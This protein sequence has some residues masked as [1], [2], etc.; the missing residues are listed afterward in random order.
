MVVQMCTTQ[1]CLQEWNEGSK[2]PSLAQH[3]EGLEVSLSL[4]HPNMHN[5]SK[6]ISQLLS[7]LEVNEIITIDS[8]ITNR[9]LDYYMENINKNPLHTL[10]IELHWHKERIWKSIKLWKLKKSPKRLLRQYLKMLHTNLFY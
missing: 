10:K 8:H 9:I 5:Q 3:I 1:I 2:K 7:P 6:K 4:M